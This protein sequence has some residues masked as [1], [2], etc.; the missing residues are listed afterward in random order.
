MFVKINLNSAMIHG[1][2]K[3]PS[4]KDFQKRC[5]SHLTYLNL[6]ENLKIL[7]MLVSS[8]YVKLKVSKVLILKS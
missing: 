8:F 1:I 3:S 4:L 2:K 6:L 7:T 5:F